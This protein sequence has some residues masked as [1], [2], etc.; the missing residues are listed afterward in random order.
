MNQPMFSI[1]GQLL[2][3]FSERQ[4]N[5]ETGEEVTRYRIQLLG[6]IPLR[7]GSDTRHDLVTLNVERL[8]DYREMEGKTIQVPFGFFAPS[9]GQVITFVPKGSKPQVVAA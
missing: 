2:K 6:A 3:A 4:V 1:T 5:K 9:K 8:S 7:D